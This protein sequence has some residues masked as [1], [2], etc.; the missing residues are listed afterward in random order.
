MKIS[1]SI[2]IILMTGI[3]MYILSGVLKGQSENRISVVA[4]V[5][6]DSIMLRWAPSSVPAFQAGARYGYVI[7]R[8]TIAKDG[9][10]IDDGLSKGI[11]LTE[12]PVKPASEDH[13]NLISHKQKEASV[14]QEALYGEAAKKAS[15]T[16]DFSSFMKTYEENEVRL[17]FALFMCDLYPEVARAAGLQFTDNDIVPG[18]RYAYSVSPALLPEGMQVE[19]GVII[20][21]AGKPTVLPPVIDVRVLFSDR[22]ARFRWPVV[23]LRGIYSAYLPERSFDGKTFVPVS[24]LPLVNLSEDENQDY[25]HFTDSLNENDTKVSYRIIGISPFGEKGPPSEVISGKGI[26]DF[27]AYAAID[28][29]WVNNGK[30]IVINW[31]VSENPDSPVKGINIMRSGNNNGPFEPINKKALSARERSFTDNNP[32]PSNYYQVMLQGSA[33]LRS[34]SFPYFVQTEDNDPPSPPEM[35]TGKVDSLGVVTIIW[36]KNTEADLLGYKV[37]KANSAKEEFIALEQGIIPENICHDLINLNTLSGKICYQVIAVDKNYNSSDYSKM[38]ELTRPDTIPPAPAIITGISA[39]TGK[40]IITQEESPSDD[41]DHYELLKIAENDSLRHSVAAWNKLL[42]SEYDD[43]QD[44]RGYYD[45]ILV[46]W[47]HSGNRSESRR[48]VFAMGSA[49]LQLK[50]TAGQSEDGKSI[51]LRWQIPSEFVPAKTVIYRGDEENSP[52]L[53]RSVEGIAMAF[54]DNDIEINKSYNYRILI[55]SANENEVLTSGKLSF[56]PLT[57]TSLK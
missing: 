13:F 22:I 6:E 10:F 47:D 48:R 49:I 38:L 19:Q 42:P 56:K 41:V 23:H 15:G 16:N 11:T 14:V 25:F 35:L 28:T 39:S 9:V 24:D 57:K 1:M 34:Y 20:A 37:F 31:R 3:L 54:I 52:S 43:D 36:K 8:F 50:L 21:D 30:S 32:G 55:Y 26:A 12:F 7:R 5:K 18:E 33:D 4:M 44:V 27:S 40:I 29:A 17:G 53:Y 45:Y 51:T 2:R 46:T